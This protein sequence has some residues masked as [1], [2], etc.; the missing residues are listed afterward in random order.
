MKVISLDQ[1]TKVTA[2][3]I[4]VD[5][6]LV[7]YGVER[8]YS[9]SERKDGME[10][11][12]RIFSIYNSIK[13]IIKKEK[14]NI[15]LIEDSY[16]GQTSNVDVLKWLCRLQGFLMELCMSMGIEYQL[17]MPTKWRKGL[18]LPN[19]RGIKRKEEKEYAIAYINKTF[20]KDFTM[21]DEDVCEA[22]CIGKYFCDLKNNA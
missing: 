13:K 11:A 12:D 14:P 8:R 9:K 2:Y 20:G 22:I 18:G 4:F 17:V 1:S 6:E 10:T 5:K 7:N 3:A 19:G 16:L 21:A 15:V